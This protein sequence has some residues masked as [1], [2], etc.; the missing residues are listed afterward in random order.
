MSSD[1]WVVKTHQRVFKLFKEVENNPRLEQKLRVGPNNFRNFQG[2]S[3][4]KISLFT[5]SVFLINHGKSY[6]KSDHKMQAI[7]AYR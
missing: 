6:K 4:Q 5:N 7:I 1:V 2:S 3:K